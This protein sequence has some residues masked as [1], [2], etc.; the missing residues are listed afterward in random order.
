[1]LSKLIAFAVSATILA[2]ATPVPQISPSQCS[3]ATLQ[4]CN[5]VESSST[6][7][8]ALIYQL[9]GIPIGPGVPTGITCSPVS[10]IGVGQAAWCVLSFCITIIF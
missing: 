9:L 1:M 7:S 10:V 6:P 5:S 2:T 4:C 8:V 3:A